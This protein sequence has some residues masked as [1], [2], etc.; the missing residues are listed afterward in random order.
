PEATRTIDFTG[1][2]DRR[3]MV[4]TASGGVSTQAVSAERLVCP[5]TERE[6][7]VAD[8]S[9]GPDPEHVREL[10]V[11]LD[12]EGQWVAG[13][14]VGS[15][16]CALWACDGGVTSFSEVGDSLTLGLETDGGCS[17]GSELAVTWD[18][19]SGFFLGNSVFTDCGGT[20]NGAALAGF[21]M[22]TTSRAAHDALATRARIAEELE[23]GAPLPAP[24][25]GVDPAYLQFGMEEPTLRADLEAEISAFTEIQVELSR[26][27]SLATEEQVR[28]FPSLVRPLGWMIDEK[29]SGR[30]VGP[31]SDRVV[32]RDTGTRP[33]IDDLGRLGLVGAH[34]QIAGN[35]LP[36]LVLPFDY[37]V[38]PG[39][40]RLVAPTA[41]AEPVYVSLGPY[42]A[43]FGPLT[44]DPSGEAKANFIGFLV[45]S[46]A[47]M[48]ELEGDMDG[49]REPGEVWGYP[50]GGDLS[51][52]RVRNRRPVYRA[53]GPGTL[54]RL[55]YEG[56]PSGNYFD[57]EPQWRVELRFYDEIGMVLGHVGKIAPSLAALVLGVTAIDPTSFVGPVGT[58]LLSGFDPIPVSANLELA[59]PQIVAD[60]VSGHDGYWGSSGFLDYPWA[61]ME[62]QLPYQLSDGLGADFC[63]YRF[64]GASNRAD[65]QA[66]M[67]LDM[68]DPVSQRYRDSPFFERWHWT[69][70]G[71]LCQA[72]SLLPRDFS[73]LDTRLGGWYERTEPGTTLDE[74]FSF[75]PIDRTAAA[76]DP[77]NY[78]SPDVDHLAI[79]FLWPGPYS[80]T[81]PDATTAMVFQAVGEVL[82]WDNASLLVMWRDLNLTNPEV[83]QRAA[84]RLDTSG[85]KIRWGNFAAIPGDAIQPPLLPGDPCSDTDTICYD[86]SLGA[87]PPGPP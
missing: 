65:L 61:Q 82:A 59:W 85:V 22:A 47:E 71:G 19:G 35:Q 8:I 5:L 32:F 79:R 69:A 1:T 72:E 3:S 81:M 48:E 52:A 55:I 6:V 24:L 57:D 34:W 87:W 21:A 83:Y 37:S 67:D 41:D 80:W 76:Y 9:G 70:Q 44:G 43:H 12:D 17:A 53:P 14:F 36:A 33:L 60:P 75:V 50:I 31:G 20:T 16:D 45:E 58:D 30:P 10:A 62:F 86:H 46:D 11:V 66:T 51:G 4:L 13:G 2:F 25:P 40:S 39:V 84:Y 29:R 7:A 23:A 74:L 56:G 28:T 77:A 54:E 49:V 64:L 15:D 38:V 73:S 27:R 63:V 26:A 78:D 68:L 18:A 42:G